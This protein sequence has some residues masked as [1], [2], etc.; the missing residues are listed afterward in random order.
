MADNLH[1]HVSRNRGAAS[2]SESV[3]PTPQVRLGAGTLN[4]PL[5]AVGILCGPAG[6]SH[7][8]W[9]GAAPGRSAYKYNDSY[10]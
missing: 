1:P 9:A 6:E 3:M 10:K 5:R 7:R 8:R 4:W 2:G